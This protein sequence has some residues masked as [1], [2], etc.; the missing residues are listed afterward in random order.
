MLMSVCVCWGRWG[1]KQITLV[2]NFGKINWILLIHLVMSLFVFMGGVKLCSFR[3]RGIKIDNFLVILLAHICFAADSW[4]LFCF[5]TSFPNGYG[6]NFVTKVVGA[7]IIFPQVP[8]TKPLCERLDLEVYRLLVNLFVFINPKSFV[9]LY[10]V[11]LVISWASRHGY[12]WKQ[13]RL[14]TLKRWKECKIFEGLASS[15]IKYRGLNIYNIYCLFSFH[16]VD[17][18][19]I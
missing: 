1:V 15:K 11:S 18:Y 12:Q 9:S 6:K 4:L 19:P 8:E 14:K 17:F 3:G 5:N 13:W 2:Y 16:L 10:F 7:L